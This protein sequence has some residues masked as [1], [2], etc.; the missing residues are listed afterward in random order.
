MFEKLVWIINTPIYVINVLLVNK[1]CL[2]TQKG[3]TRRL[4]TNRTVKDVIKWTLLYQYN[5][6]QRTWT[7]SYTGARNGGNRQMWWCFCRWSLY[8]LDKLYYTYSTRIK[9]SLFRPI[10]INISL[11]SRLVPQIGHLESV[12]V[13]I[14]TSVFVQL[15]SS[16]SL[17]CTN[18]TAM[19]TNE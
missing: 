15:N 10:I 6:T 18:L 17:P 1:T 3:E 14:P 9:V 4:N 12:H 13:Y 8:W 7:V 5:C 11:L 2:L 16:I 19:C